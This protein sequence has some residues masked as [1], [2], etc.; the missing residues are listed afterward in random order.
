MEEKYHSIIAVN[1]GKEGE[2]LSGC[3]SI[4]RMPVRGVLRV[5]GDSIDAVVE[6]LQPEGFGEF[7]H[8]CTLVHLPPGDE[9]Y[10]S[11][12]A[13]IHDMKIREHRV[14]REKDGEGCTHGGCCYGP[15]SREYFMGVDKQGYRWAFATSGEVDPIDVLDLES[16]NSDFERK[17][18]LYIREEKYRKKEQGEK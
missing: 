14:I 1:V 3:L 9:E 12:G 6:P 16:A 18:R 17:L 7:E 4:L 10:R 13:K 15:F 2:Y 8:L 11:F 5:R